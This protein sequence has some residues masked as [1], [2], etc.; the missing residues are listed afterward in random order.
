M[1]RTPGN[2]RRFLIRI[3]F[4]NLCIVGVRNANF[5]P[6]RRDFNRPPAWR[7]GFGRDFG[8]ICPLVSIRLLR[9]KQV[10][11]RRTLS[12]LDQALRSVA[13]SLSGLW[14]WGARGLEGGLRVGTISGPGGHP[15]NYQG[16]MQRC[17]RATRQF[18]CVLLRRRLIAGDAHDRMRDGRTVGI[19]TPPD[20]CVVWKQGLAEDNVGRGLGLSEATVLV[21]E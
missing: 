4:E 20:R 5:R 11:K 14:I 17:L 18:P 13:A 21:R 3:F 15:P 10:L 12:G 16:S 2:G 7:P 19:S 6:N 1:T 9:P 8:S